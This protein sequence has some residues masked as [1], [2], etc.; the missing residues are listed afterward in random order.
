VAKI[1]SIWYPILVSHTIHARTAG[2]VI[3]LTIMDESKVFVIARLDS[4]VGYAKQKLH[5]IMICIH[6]Q[7][8]VTV[9]KISVGVGL[10]TA[11]KDV[12]YI[13]RSFLIRF[14]ICKINSLL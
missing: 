5:V 1:A 12:K 13:V 11:V 9:M 2:I 3:L 10:I 4:L 8:M 6:A 14:K 7:T